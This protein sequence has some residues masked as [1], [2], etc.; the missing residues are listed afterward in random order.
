MPALA[1]PWRKRG[2]ERVH[3]MAELPAE[4]DAEAIDDWRCGGEAGHWREGRQLAAVS[5]PA[6]LAAAAVSGRT[7]EEGSR[8]Q[9]G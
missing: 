1:L 3:G 6:R 9:S 2:R 4:L 8:G 5:A 7:S